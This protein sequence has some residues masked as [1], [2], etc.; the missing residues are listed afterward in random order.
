M[1]CNVKNVNKQ[2][3]HAHHKRPAEGTC[4]PRNPTIENKKVMVTPIFPSHVSFIVTV[5]FFFFSSLLH[6][7]VTH[8]HFNDSELKLMHSTL[9]EGPLPLDPA[10]ARN[11]LMMTLR[12]R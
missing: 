9:H 7:R 6:G 2:A 8:P 1:Q 5:T 3:H 12:T 10:P 11:E 4:V